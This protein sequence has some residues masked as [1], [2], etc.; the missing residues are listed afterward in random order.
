MKLSS[1]C[2]V[3]PYFGTWPFWMP[4]FL[5]SCRANP[6][7]NWIFYTDCGV[8]EQC[9]GNV[10]VV[11]MSFSEYSL[12]VSKKLGINF[13]PNK[14]YKLCDIRPAFGLIHEEDLIGYDFWAF[15][16]IDLIFGDIR[17]FFLES[18]LDGMDLISTHTRRVSGHC[19]LIRNNER[20]KHAFKRIPD[21]ESRFCKQKHEALDE[22]AF[23]RI[24]I[25]HKNW[26]YWIYRL[27]AN[28]NPWYRRARFVEAFS[29]PGAKVPWVD[30]SFNFPTR[31][32]WRNGVLTNDLN[33]ERRFLYLHFIVWK[34]QVW[35]NLCLP[36]PD[37]LV[38]LARSG[39][40][41]V[42]AEGF[43]SLTESIEAERA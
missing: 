11:S 23:S 3:M 6:T 42:D 36:R 30:G 24:F 26:P 25:R 32:F 41:S 40:W 28:F 8:L 12:F 34:K 43:H 22:G 27:A 19:C 14:P 20:M 21:W 38:R 37:E 4:F 31:W 13:S 17:Y 15:G 5:E 33:G 7:V 9:P 29:T 39:G 35:S 2:F 1:I 16:D 18:F 10:K